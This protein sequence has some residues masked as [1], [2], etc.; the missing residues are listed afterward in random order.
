MLGIGIANYLALLAGI[1]TS[2]LSFIIALLFR[3][4]SHAIFN[5]GYGFNPVLHGVVSVGALPSIYPEIQVFP[6][7]FWLFLLITTVMSVY[8]TSA[9]NNLFKH[10]NQ[11]PIPCFSL[12]FNLL[13]F[14]LIYCLL[15]NTM[16]DGILSDHLLTAPAF[17]L[18]ETA[19]ESNTTEEI[20]NFTENATT[21]P[22][23]SEHLNWGETYEG[24][25]VAISQV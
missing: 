7:K 11:Y 22:L 17:R 21:E 2:T 6:P 9:F 16:P 15:H 24:T 14:M 18:N 1:Y 5:G 12:P 20:F 23:V 10:I 3:Q 13:Q 8:A 25:I 19:L 4:D